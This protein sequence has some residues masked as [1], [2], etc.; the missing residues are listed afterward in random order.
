[1][2]YP[3]FSKNVFVLWLS[4]Y[5]PKL[6][7]VVYTTNRFTESGLTGF[8]YMDFGSWYIVEDKEKK[9]LSTIMEKHPECYIQTF[10]FNEVNRL[11]DIMK[12]KSVKH[13]AIIP[14]DIKVGLIL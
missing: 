12:K 3:V 6:F 9:T 8:W 13:E 14:I 7:Y 1:M 2:E 5:W 10:Y 4:G 11:V